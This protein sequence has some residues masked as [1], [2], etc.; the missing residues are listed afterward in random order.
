MGRNV[1]DTRRL[2][3]TMSGYDSRFPLSLRD[4]VSSA[5]KPSTLSDYKVGWMGDYNG[6][7]TMEDGVLDL[8]T[9]VLKSLASNGLAVEDCQPNYSMDRLWQTWLT[10]RHWTIASGAKALYDNPKLK[11]LLKP[12]I[13]WEVEGGLEQTG[14]DISRA[15]VD[16]SAWYQSLDALFQEHDFLALPS[17]Q[18]FAFSAETHWPKEINGKKMDTYH[19]WM[20]V[21]VGGTL[22]GCPV[23]N[24]PVGF[25]KLGRAMGMQFI[26]PMGE[27]EKL[28][29]FA[30]AYEANTNFLSIRPDLHT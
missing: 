20:E 9:T 26:A 15:A 25:D 29:D 16:R 6:Y 14:L 21:V 27:D 5:F 24:L 3:A 1:E 12:E 17:A 2:L 18:V 8:C 22:A 4:T 13:I 23:I 28:L 11:P 7:L 10:L 30:A 19:R